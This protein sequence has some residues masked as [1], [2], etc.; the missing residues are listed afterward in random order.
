MPGCGALGS[1]RIGRS[2]DHI[3]TARGQGWSVRAGGRDETN[4]GASTYLYVGGKWIGASLNERR[5]NVWFVARFLRS[6]S[7]ARSASLLPLATA[8]TT[9]SRRASICSEDE[10]ERPRAVRKRGARVREDALGS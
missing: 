5:R 7:C 9:A 1:S 4:E 3:C 6:W 10:R 2:L 8:E